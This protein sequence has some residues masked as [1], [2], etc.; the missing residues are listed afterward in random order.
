M[1]ASVAVLLRTAE[2]GGDA[3]NNR[4]FRV[5]DRLNYYKRHLGD[6]A[7]NTRTLSTYE[8]GVYSLLLDQYYT[9]EEPLTLEDAVAVCRAGTRKETDSVV[10]VLNRYFEERDGR[11]HNSRADEEITKYHE[12]S[13][14]NAEIGRLG[15]Q[16]KAKRL[17]SETLGES[18]SGTPEECLANDNPSHKPLA[19]SQEPEKKKRRTR[20]KR[21][22]SKLPDGFG[23][24][25]RVR[26]WAQQHGHGQLERRHEHFVGKARAK[27]YTYADWDQAFMNAI[28]DDWAKLGAA[29]NGYDVDL[30]V[31][32]ELQELLQR[33]ARKHMGT[34]Q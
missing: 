24:S 14:K 16:R 20:E 17:S 18:P 21:S 22:E 28:A 1:R 12:K 8:H 10:R 7:K 26:S 9:D 30:G 2:P 6:Y 13:I 15:G 27:G 4:R 33:E 29:T 31:D 3:A 25:E 5:E 34:V 32:P 23:I 19:N 11:W